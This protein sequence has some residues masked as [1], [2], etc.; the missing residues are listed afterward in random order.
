MYQLL[1]VLFTIFFIIL[2]VVKGVQTGLTLLFASIFLSLFLAPQ[3]FFDI[4]FEALTYEKT[5]FLISISAA[6]SILAE[7]YRRTRMINDL[8]IGLVKV[9][10]SSKL[11]VVVTP[12]IIGLLPVAGGALMSAPI[13]DALKDSLGFSLDMAVY[14][15]VWFR[16]TI[17]MFYPLSQLLITIS[18][19]TGVPIETLALR[20][21]PISLFMVLVGYIISFKDAKKVSKV[22]LKVEKFPLKISI[23]PLLSSL[24]SAVLLKSFFGDF[25]MVLGVLIGIF[26]LI[27]LSKADFKVIV[28]SLNN[29]RVRGVTFAAFSIMYLQKAFVLSGG[30]YALTSSIISLNIPLIV[31]EFTIPG[32]LSLISGSTLTGVVLTLPI[33]ESIGSLSSLDVSSIFISSYLYYLASPVHLC[34]VYTAEYFSRPLTKAYKYMLPSVLLSLLFAFIYFAFLSFWIGV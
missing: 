21:I 10:K 17:F 32:F 31:L 4:L 27:W 1:I 14:A 9:L 19:L 24:V 20:H 2:L 18:A 22:E 12:A 15:N 7:M 28:S 33:F 5:W 11:A 23:T 16:H 8:G 26:S 6:I 25:G 29:S 3:K 34:F 30:A 13:V